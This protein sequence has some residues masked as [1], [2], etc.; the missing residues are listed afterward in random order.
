[1]LSFS[2]RFGVQFKS[3]AML[4]VEKLVA[5]LALAAF[6]VFWP[7]NSNDLLDETRPVA[8]WKIGAIAALSA[9]SILHLGRLSEF[10]YFNF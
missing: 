10:I 2:K 7:R 5:Y 9:F 3:L 4:D 1:V 8:S 6:I